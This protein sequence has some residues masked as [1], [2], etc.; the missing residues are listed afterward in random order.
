[1]V[2]TEAGASVVDAERRDL[3]VP[4]PDAR[5][6]LLAAGTPELLTA[7]HEGLTP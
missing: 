4:D 2:C 7:L 5:R 1:L 6:Q 3:V